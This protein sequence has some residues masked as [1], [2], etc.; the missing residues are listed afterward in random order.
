M[1]LNEYIKGLRNQIEQQ[2][3]EIDRLRA[4]LDAVV[5]H[6]EAISEELSR[7]TCELAGYKQAAK[8]LQ[9][10]EYRSFDDYSREPVLVD[11]S[12]I[13][14]VRAFRYHSFRSA[15]GQV[16]LRSGEKINVWEDVD[17]I[18]RMMQRAARA[19]GGDDG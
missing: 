18:K 3:D 2:R 12:E 7:K 17:T 4:K 10:T 8:M 14:A 16:V 6:R 1:V 15:I 9:L 11:E 19:A 13:A 5:R